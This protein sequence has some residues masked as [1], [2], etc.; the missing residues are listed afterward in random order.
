MCV[1]YRYESS[2]V[3]GYIIPFHK[4]FNGLLILLLIMNCYWFSLISRIAY[5]TVVSGSIDVVREAGS[6]E[7]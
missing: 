3:L 1:L 5:R 4:A 6:E 7:D 2:E